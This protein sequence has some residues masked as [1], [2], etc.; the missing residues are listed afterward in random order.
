MIPILIT[1]VEEACNE[2]ANDISDFVT[3]AKSELNKLTTNVLHPLAEDDLLYART[4]ELYLDKIVLGNPT[5]LR[6]YKAVFEDFINPEVMKSDAKKEFRN[7]II[8]ALDYKG[9]RSKFLPKYFQYLGI[10]ACIYCNSQITVSVNITEYNITEVKRIKTEKTTVKAK[11]Q[12][13]HYIP[14]SDYPCFSISLYNLY[15]VCAS[16][17]NS[18]STTPLNFDLYTDDIS[19]TKKSDYSFKL[20][21]GCVLDYLTSGNKE[22]IEVYFMD[23]QKPDREITV[24]G[25]F[26]DTFDIE[27]IYETQKDLV[28]ELILKAKIYDD[29]YKQTLIKSFP[30]L[31]TNASLSNRFFL[32]NYIDPED[33]HKRP[34]AK[35][36]QDIARQLEL[37]K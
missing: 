26:Q 16:C 30:K 24:E 35:F 36:V 11:F 29:S 31:F 13:D 18:K 37:I 17:N 9:I 33:I 19:K 5:Q 4:L 12:V 7:N 20:K 6:I 23:P 21:D 32:G 1:Q 14:K 34:M 10:K 2:Y 25:S 8:D 3:T 27:G 22:V 15:P 28:E